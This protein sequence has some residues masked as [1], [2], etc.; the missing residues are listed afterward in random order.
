[1]QVLKKVSLYKVSLFCHVKRTFF[2]SK[3]LELPQTSKSTVGDRWQAIGKAQWL[4][5]SLL[6]LIYWVEVHKLS[7]VQEFPGHYSE[8]PCGKHYQCNFDN[9]K[10]L[11][12][13]I[14]SL[15]EAYSC[16]VYHPSNVEFTERRMM[17]YSA[18]NSL[19]FNRRWNGAVHLCSSFIFVRS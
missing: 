6:W 9:F 16:G 14:L 2:N 12:P 10:S 15:S 8:A 7:W 3:A 4:A 19:R 17:V 1:M 5:T 18:I 13:V 11:H